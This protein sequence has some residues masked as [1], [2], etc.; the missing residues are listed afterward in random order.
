MK[1]NN[2]EKTFLIDLFDVSEKPSVVVINGSP[3]ECQKMAERLEL[4]DI[5]DLSA[6][7]EVSKK[8]GIYT[9]SGK[10]SCEVL[11][12]DAISLEEFWEIIDTEVSEDF[13]IGQPDKNSSD[14]EEIYYHEGNEIDMFEVASEYIS[15]EIPTFP[16]MSEEI[17][18]HKE[19][20][21]E[22]KNTP[23]AGLKDAL[24]KKN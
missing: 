20:E 5:K 10:I 23:F 14:I 22:E 21:T 4:K 2:L 11:L 12:T 1:K 19:F 3:K 8:F 6:K 24:A 16:R 13:K 15:L 9:L 17:F 7:L 18:V